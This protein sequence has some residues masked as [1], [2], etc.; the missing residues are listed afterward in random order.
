MNDF[1]DYG[2]TG[3][4][5]PI[6]NIG[7]PAI[8]VTPKLTLIPVDGRGAV[9]KGI[10]AEENADRNACASGPSWSGRLI[11]KTIAFAGLKDPDP[12][13]HWA[14]ARICEIWIARNRASGSPSVYR[15]FTD[16]GFL[17]SSC[18][19]LWAVARSSVRQA[20]CDFRRSCSSLAWAAS[21]SSEAVRSL[22]SAACFSKVPARS[23]AAA[24]FS[25][26]IC[27]TAPASATSRLSAASLMFPD[28]TIAYVA[29]TPTNSA[30]TRIQFAHQNTSSA[31]MPLTPLIFLPF[32][33]IVVI[34]GMGIMIGMLARR[35][36]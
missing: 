8:A 27:A 32:V 5:E 1:R 10:P 35:T 31:D 7:A 17:L 4:F 20:S 24:A 2:S 36:G 3:A 16:P 22:A 23:V 28:N 29:A 18:S 6:I 14:L 15:R 21:F 34:A 9:E 25:L 33:L 30:P 26:A 11:P 19:N 13:A 12:I